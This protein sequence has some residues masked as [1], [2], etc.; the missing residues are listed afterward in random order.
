MGGDSVIVGNRGRGLWVGL[1]VGSVMAS[2]NECGLGGVMILHVFCRGEV[3][4]IVLDLVA[5][6]EL[7]TVGDK[8]EDTC[9]RG[10]RLTIPGVFTVGMAR[11]DGLRLQGIPMLSALKGGKER[12]VLKGNI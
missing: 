3:I 2:S 10:L 12:R 11:I 6:G 5:G 1:R 7:N 4:R 9:T 8:T